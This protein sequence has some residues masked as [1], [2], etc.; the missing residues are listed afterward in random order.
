MKFGPHREDLMDQVL[1]AD[2]VMLAQ[3][4]L[5]DG[6]VGQGD[7]L[8][9]DLAMTALVDQ[10]P[11]GLQVGLPVGDVRIHDSEHALGGL[12]QTDKDTVVD[13]AQDEGVAGSSGALDSSC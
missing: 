13:L 3:G 9:V 5:D 1:H 10:V 7:A 4:G 11:D 2:D 8:L 6:V 12:G